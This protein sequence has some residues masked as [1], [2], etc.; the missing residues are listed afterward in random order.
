MLPL[1]L[2]LPLLWASDPLVGRW[3]AALPESVFS[4]DFPALR[5]QT[6]NCVPSG[7]GVRCVAVRV[8]AQGSR[9]E[10]EFTARYD[11]REY[12]VTG[13]PDVDAV[14]LRRT[15]QTVE[16]TFLKAHHATFA[17]RIAFSANR[18]RLTITSLHPDT[19]QKLRSIVVYERN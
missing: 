4:P 10:M 11:G 12:P 7:Q 14:V 19:R 2:L 1:A 8:T 13:S 17:Y 5:C 6:L 15:G 18:R 9:S 3:R 16:G